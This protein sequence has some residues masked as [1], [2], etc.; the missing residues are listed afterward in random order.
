MLAA[1]SKDSCCIPVDT[2]RWINVGLTLVQR[3]RRWTNVKST[4][5]QRLVPAGIPLLYDNISPWQALL[6]QWRLVLLYL[7]H[8]VTHHQRPHLQ[9]HSQLVT[10][11]TA[12]S[13]GAAPSAVFSAAEAPSKLKTNQSREPGH[14]CNLFSRPQQP[15]GHV[16]FPK[17]EPSAQN[18]CPC[19]WAKSNPLTWYTL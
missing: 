14:P 12:P 5:I 16:R 3:R 7:I 10:A 15:S 11:A 13:T 1:E 6:H 8:Q 9:Q 2:R 18:S 19:T 4:L 17:P